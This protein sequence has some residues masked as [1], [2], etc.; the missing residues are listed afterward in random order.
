MKITLHLTYLFI[1]LVLILIFLD[2]PLNAQRVG[3]NVYLKGSNIEI[4]IDGLGGFEGCDINVS[5]PPAGM[6]YQSNTPYFGFVANPQK[7]NW[8]TFDGDF[9]TPGTPRNGWGIEIPSMGLINGNNRAYSSEIPG[10]ITSYTQNF[11]CYS[12]TWEGNIS[13]LTI[14]VNYFLQ[15]SDLFYTTTINITNNTG[16]TIPEMFYYRSLDPDNNVIL[17]SIYAT[18]NKIG[19]QPGS[20]ACNVAL[21]SATQNVPWNSYLGLAAIGAEWKAGYGGFLN[22]DGSDLWNGIGLRTQTV[23][24]SAYTDEEIYLANRIQ[25]FAAGETK[26]LR[27]VVILSASDASKAINNLVQLAHPSGNILASVCDPNMD[28]VSACKGV[29]TPI[30]VQGAI[31]NNFTWTWSPMTNLD[32]IRPDSIVLNPSV[33]TTYTVTGNPR[34]NCF[35]PISISFALKVL[36]STNTGVPDDIIVCNG[37]I[38]PVG[39]FSNL[40]GSVFNW[41]NSNTGIGLAA[42]GNGNIPSFTA[43]NSGL[44]PLTATITVYTSLTGACTGEAKTYTITVNN[45]PVLNITNPAAI[46]F[47]A[48]INIGSVNITQGSD[49]NLTFTYWNDAATT[50]ALA[51]SNAI[52]ASGTYYIKATTLAGCETIKPVSVIVNPLPNLVVSNPAAVCQLQ[53]VAINVPSVTAG[54]SGVN[55]LSYWW[56]PLTTS[57]LAT[58]EA[59]NSGTYYIKA[60][61]TE[62]CSVIKPIT[63]ISQPNPLLVINNPAAVCEPETIDFTAAAVTNGSSNIGTLSYWNDAAATTAL[64]QANAITLSGIYYIKATSPDGCTDTKAVTSR[65]FSTPE[66]QFDIKLYSGC[67]PQCVNFNNASVL[68]NNSSLISMWRWDFGDGERGIEQNPTHCYTNPGQYNISLTALSNE[69]CSFSVNVPNMVSVFANP[70]ADFTAPSST[71]T[72]PEIQFS[73]NSTEASEWSWNFGEPSSSANSSTL[74]NPNHSYADTG[75][76]CT[77]LIVSNSFGC[78]DSIEKCIGIAPETHFYI[79]N[80]FSPNEDGVNDSF[81][82]KG[83][84]FSEFE[85]RV[86]NRWGK[87]IFH[88]NDINTAWNGRVNNTGDIVQEDVYVYIVKL[89]NADKELLNYTGAV[90]L[91]K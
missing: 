49:A 84:Y 40:P 4:G 70:T 60:S 39:N 14:S 89:K 71:I 26:T 35:Q 43:I 16:N 72:H 48:T 24:D 67:A 27:F 46:C 82:G 88:S 37:D 64:T 68:P 66:I 55:T 33:N 80:S 34:N 52:S 29:P 1:I 10:T 54:S 61:S 41:T 5:T 17:N 58:P 47:P 45:K 69:G 59:L 91:I 36:P 25:N 87:Q 76:Y 13:G 75:Y 11:S 28:T 2:F 77:I 74:K 50:N 90:T 23:N 51:N 65:I 42:S 12:T 79:P 83:L 73:N 31:I 21:V 6:H 8:N 86:F 30:Q 85:M 63:V 81:F 78:K 22:I 7:N 53:T 32:L 3:S 62:G 44:T 56:D 19:S 9:F 57:A 18:N 15:E 20:D 38:V